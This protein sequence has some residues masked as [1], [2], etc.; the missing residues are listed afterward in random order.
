MTLGKW[1][2]EWGKLSSG[3]RGLLLGMLHLYLEGIKLRIAKHARIWFMSGLIVL[4]LH[5]AQIIFTNQG[6]ENSLNLSQGFLVC[7]AF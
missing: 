2:V 4:R 1:L 3:V 7:Q 5:F 6:L